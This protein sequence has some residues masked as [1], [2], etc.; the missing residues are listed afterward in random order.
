[1]QITIPPIPRL[2]LLIAVFGLTSC[3]SIKDPEFQRIE[4]IRFGKLGLTESILN[5]DILY[6]NPNK[7]RLKLKSAEGEAWLDNTYLGRFI[8]DTLI[9]IP[10][11]DLFRLPVKLQV[12]MSKIVQSSVLAFLNPE[13]VIKINGKARVGKGFIYINYPIKYEGKQNLRE[14]IK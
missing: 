3:G 11:N 13:V 1:M 8:I 10:A 4:N 14:L 2:L 6:L 9:K 12:D 5:L 7:T